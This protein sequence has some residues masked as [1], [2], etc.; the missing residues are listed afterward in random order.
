MPRLLIVIM[1]KETAWGRD[2]TDVLDA[3]GIKFEL[4]D[5]VLADLNGHGISGRWQKL[6]A[7]T[8]TQYEVC[9]QRPQDP[10]KLTNP[11]CQRIVLLNSNQVILKDINKLMRKD[12]AYGDIAASHFCTCNSNE[13]WQAN[14]LSPLNHINP[15]SKHTF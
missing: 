7:W 12:L 8:L 1:A 15:K 11:T 14:R 6:S 13:P 5:R 10:V 4:V 9:K 2:I 3:A